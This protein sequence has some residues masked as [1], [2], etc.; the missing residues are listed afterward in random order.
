MY[1][2]DGFYGSFDDDFHVGKTE[3]VLIKYVFDAFF[4][5]IE[6]GDKLIA[7]FKWGLEGHI[8]A[9]YY[10]VDAFGVELGET[11]AGSRQ[12]FVTGVLYVV[13][14]VGVVYDALQIAFVIA[15]LH[16]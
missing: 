1:Y 14:V 16:F 5:E 11:D 12:K 13:L 7:A 15:Y 4:L 9:G 6:L 3:D 8:E 2:T 10:G